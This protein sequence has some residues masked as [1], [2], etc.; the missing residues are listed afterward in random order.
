MFGCLR[1]HPKA[2][3]RVKVDLCLANIFIECFWCL[4]WYKLVDYSCCLKGLYIKGLF[5]TDTPIKMVF[6]FLTATNS[7]FVISISQYPSRPWPPWCLP[8]PTQAGRLRHIC[9]CIHSLCHG[10]GRI[11]ELGPVLTVYK[12]NFYECSQFIFSQQKTLSKLR[13]SIS[14]T[15]RVVIS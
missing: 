3:P 15:I 1:A 11:M 13:S 4:L 14:Q 5:I 6:I 8:G 7:F 2:D 10:A 12:W 9:R